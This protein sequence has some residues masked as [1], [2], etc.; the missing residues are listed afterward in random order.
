MIEY[1]LGYGHNL[2]QTVIPCDPVA[3]ALSKFKFKY[4]YSM[5]MLF[6][7]IAQKEAIVVE[8]FKHQCE[9]LDQSD[10]STLV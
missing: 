5:S 2:G 9:I 1:N 6:P 7:K 8:L 10:I 4:Y 3:H